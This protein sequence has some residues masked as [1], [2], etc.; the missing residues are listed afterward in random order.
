MPALGLPP[1]RPLIFIYQAHP[2]PFRWAHPL[3]AHS[4]HPPTVPWKWARPLSPGVKGKNGELCLYKWL[5]PLLCV[6]FEPLS[7]AQSSFLPL[8]LDTFFFFS[9]LYARLSK[10]AATGTHPGPRG[11]ARAHFPFHLKEMLYRCHRGR[12]VFPRD[13]KTTWLTG[14]QVGRSERRHWRAGTRLSLG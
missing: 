8:S 10:H 9:G 14:V 5:R 11:L 6:R 2:W 1:C 3:P 12:A 4:P 7:R 13:V